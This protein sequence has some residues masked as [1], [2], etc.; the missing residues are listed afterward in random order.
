MSSQ[1][2]LYIS[3]VLKFLHTEFWI[4]FY[5]KILSGGKTLVCIC[6]E[7]YWSW[8]LLRLWHLWTNIVL[9][10]HNYSID[11]IIVLWFLPISK[12]RGWSIWMKEASQVPTQY[13]LH[14]SLYHLI[15]SPPWCT[16]YTRSKFTVESYRALTIHIHDNILKICLCTL[17]KFLVHFSFHNVQSSASAHARRMQK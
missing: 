12:Y 10:I 4:N 1:L 15:S 3:F 7:E 16:V 5:R 2:C 14:V 6:E 17:L 8:V 13:G 11:I 9:L